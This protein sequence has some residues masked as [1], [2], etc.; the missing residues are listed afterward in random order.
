MEN[1]KELQRNNP[2]NAKILYFSVSDQTFSFWILDSGVKTPEKS[3]EKS[4][5]KTPEKKSP[6]F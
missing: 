6:L 3:S 1:V 5:E 4:P 2:N